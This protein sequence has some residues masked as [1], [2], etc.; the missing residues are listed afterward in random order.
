[1]SKFWKDAVERIGWTAA[2]AAIPAAAYYVDLLP[3][4]W[5]PVAT[6][7]LTVVKTLVAKHFG[8]PETATFD[9]K[10]SA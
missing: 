6:V 7:I 1:M 10:E 5:I 2:A 8:N 9:K 4:Q 3:V